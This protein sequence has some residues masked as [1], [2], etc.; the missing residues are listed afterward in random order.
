MKQFVLSAL[1]DADLGIEDIKLEEQNM[2]TLHYSE[3][4]SIWFDWNEESDGTHRLFDML[5]YIYIALKRGYIVCI[6]EFDAHLHPHITRS[7]LEFFQ[8]PDINTKG[9]QLLIT[10]HDTNLMRPSRLRR[11]QIWIAEKD[12]ESE[13]NLYS[14]NDIEDDRPG[15]STEMFVR[16]YLA[17]EYGGVPFVG[18]TF[19]EPRMR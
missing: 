16:H 4:N 5:G 14:L 8:H 13:T 19:A 7:L 10:T 2:K 1:K 15:R 9:A 3:G 12:R 18:R 17:G 11:D 6:D